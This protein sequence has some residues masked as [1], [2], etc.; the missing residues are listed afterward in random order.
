MLLQS[1]LQNVLHLFYPHQCCGCGSDVLSAKE[2]LCLKC[3]AHLPYTQF[4]SLQGNIVEKIF[5]GRVKIESAFS[6]LYFSRHQLVQRLI[7]QF[8]YGGNKKLGEFLGQLMGFALQKNSRFDTL[9]I[10][11]PLPLHADKEFK[12]GFNQAEILCKG[13]QQVTGLPIAENIS[14]T[15]EKFT[16]TQTKKHRAERWQNVENSF[17]VHNPGLLINTHAL[18]VDDVVTTGATLESCAMAMQHIDGI[19]VS[20]ATLALANK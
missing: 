5:Y 9:N 13:I 2:M 12:R 3:L 19:K 18:I 7:H 1:Y 16:E 11:I 17:A 15:R 4:E 6:L 8:K 20:I 10:L 14:V